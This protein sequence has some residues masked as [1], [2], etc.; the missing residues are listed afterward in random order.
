MRIALGLLI[1][2]LAGILQGSPAIEPD[3]V[4]AKLSRIRLDKNEFY[5]ARDITIRRDALTL[6]LNRGVIAF[7]EPVN[8]KI[9][10]A[11]FIGDGEIVAIPPDA[12][13][14]QQLY[15]FTGT[16]IL[17]EPFQTGIFRFTDGTYEEIRKEI[18]K[19]AEEQVSPDDIAQFAPWDMSLAGRSTVLNL[20]L[21]ADFL[22]PPGKPLF[23]AEL[24][25]NK[26]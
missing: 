25:G 24:Q 15:K 20:R 10:G 4:L 12:I 5:V 11:V 21:L 13:E 26:T 7:L 14:K 1:A 8:G 18:S 2:I 3:Q 16:P 19:H 22:E 9:T 17:N 6:A 23:L